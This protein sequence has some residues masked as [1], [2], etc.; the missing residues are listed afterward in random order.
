M[1]GPNTG[2]PKSGKPKGVSM[3]EIEKVLKRFDA[4]IEWLMERIGMR[5]EIQRMTLDDE[6][7]ARE[8]D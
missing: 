2:A 4:S 1:S 8:K 3:R 6:M 7:E 5:E